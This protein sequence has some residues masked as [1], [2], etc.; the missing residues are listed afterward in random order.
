MNP[1]WNLYPIK[2]RKSSIKPPLSSKPPLFRGGKLIS[3]PPLYSPSLL[4][5]PSLLSPPSKVLEK[6]RPP[7]GLIE[8]LR[9]ILWLFIDTLIINNNPIGPSLV[10]ITQIWVVIGHQYGFSAVVPHMSFPSPR[11]Q[12]WCHEMLTVFSG[13]KLSILSCLVETLDLMTVLY[14][15]LVEL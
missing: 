2:Y 10:N 11:N 12:W 6:N 14:Y 7:G 8:D 9:Y 3:P 4:R 13:Y 15:Y 5:P 1:L